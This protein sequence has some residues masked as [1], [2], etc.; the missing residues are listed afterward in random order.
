MG[1]GRIAHAT[2]ARL[3]PFGFTQCL[4]FSNPSSP[5]KL[6]RDASLAASLRL[7]PDSIRRVNLEVVAEESDV[8]FVLTPGGKET[9]NLVDEAFL[10]KMKKTSVLVNTSRGSVVDSD[11]LAKA[12]RERWI[13]GAGLDVLTGEP[14]IPA[15][16]PL[17]RE[18]RYVFFR[19]NKKNIPADDRR[20]AT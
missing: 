2:L 7:A 9:N 16:H 1:F 5:A 19:P 8:V 18:S 6:S 3:I 12:L 20:F 10:R 4:Y 17:V 14:K 11:A 15:D 13:W